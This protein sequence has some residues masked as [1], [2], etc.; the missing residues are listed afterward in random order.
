MN[1]FIKALQTK[2]QAKIDEAVATI[3]L[4]LNAPVGVG[5][6]P[7]IL[8]VLDTYVQMLDDN[9]GKLQVLN[10]FIQ[11]PEVKSNDKP[12]GN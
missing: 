12:S 6:H 4:Y 10:T 11:P 8:D 2:Y 1:R 5:E 7:D 9:T 3:E